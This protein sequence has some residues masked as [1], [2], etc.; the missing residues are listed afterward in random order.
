MKTCLNAATLRQGLS[1]TEFIDVAGAAGYEGIELRIAAAQEYIDAHG[2]A[3][4]LERL[5]RAGLGLASFGY[6]APIRSRPEEFARG[7]AAMPAVCELAARL[8]LRGGAAGLP[9]RQG[10]GYTV[11]REETIERVGQIGRIAARYG[12]EV[13]LEF[14]ALHPPDHIAWTKTL[15]Q[16]LDIAEA[17]GQ[18][19]VGAL[20][21]SYHWRACTPFQYLLQA[22]QTSF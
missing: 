5:E 10:E 4:L 14:I 18:P 22:W 9:F 17:A 2:E 1:L 19:N 20:I 11:T 16:T 6:P 7:L 15:G 3:A 12:L 21:D 13:Y 8:G